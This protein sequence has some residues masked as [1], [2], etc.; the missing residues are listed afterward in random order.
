MPE[1]VKETWTL[2]LTPVEEKVLEVPFKTG[3]IDRIIAIADPNN[4]LV[5][6]SEYNNKSC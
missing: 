5:E 1:P 3:Y 4:T 2:T 6:E